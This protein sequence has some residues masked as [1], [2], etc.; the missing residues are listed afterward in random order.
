MEKNNILVYGWGGGKREGEREGEKAEREREREREKAEE[1]ERD[2]EREREKERER[3]ER[4]EDEEQK[5]NT[6]TEKQK[7][8]Q[9]DSQ[10]DRPAASEGS[11]WPLIASERQE[12]SSEESRCPPGKKA[13]AKGPAS[14]LMAASALPARSRSAS[15][16]VIKSGAAKAYWTFPRLQT[17]MVCS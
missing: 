12:S 16:H 6:K 14:S 17:R 9:T 3:R 13:I 5:T 4:E 10:P 2:R 11:L 8:T 7:Q 1:R 15:P